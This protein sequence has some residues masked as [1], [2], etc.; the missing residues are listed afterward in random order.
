M[1]FIQGPVLQE[2]SAAK[3]LREATRKFPR[4]STVEY[5]ETELGF[6][7]GRELEPI[8]SF[9]PLAQQTLCELK[10]GWGHWDKH[11]WILVKAMFYLEGHPKI[12]ELRGEMI[13]H[14][15]MSKWEQ[16]ISSLDL[17]KLQLLSLEFASI[18]SR[19]L[20]PHR[21]LAIFLKRAPNLRSLQIV[22][23]DYANVGSDPA[24]FAPSKFLDYN[25][26]WKNLMELSLSHMVLTLQR[27]KQLLLRHS[28]TLRT[29][30][31][32]HMTL[33]HGSE[34]VFGSAR[35]LWISMIVFLSQ[36]MSLEHVNLVGYFTTDTNEA[37][38]TVGR[39]KSVYVSPPRYK[40]CLLDR[41]ERF[42]THVGS[43]PFTLKLPDALSDLDIGSNYDVRTWTPEHSWTWKEDDTW[44]LVTFWLNE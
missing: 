7:S 26:Q 12:T 44:S 21:A 36:S 35:A 27:L 23:W 32:S 39:E 11:F 5:A 38:S 34:P 10:M 29:L 24:N 16:L 37:W 33:H 14:K 17:R 3:W 28:Q 42:I 30:K 4:L 41:I 13:D 8:S 20:A 25:L 40:G 43:C 6:E 19:S 31:L 18:E 9:S 15:N 22:L 1:Q 2:D